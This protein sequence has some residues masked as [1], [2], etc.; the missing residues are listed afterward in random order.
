MSVP[1]PIISDGTLVT[2]SRATSGFE[3]VLVKTAVHAFAL[4]EISEA[5]KVTTF[6]AAEHIAAKMTR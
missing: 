1:E 2:P 5:T 3:A 4:L 6:M